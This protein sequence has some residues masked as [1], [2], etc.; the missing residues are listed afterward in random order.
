MK[1][2]PLFVLMLVVDFII[3][4]LWVY[5]MDPDP[6]SGIALV[7]IIPSVLIF[8]LL[9]GGVFYWAKKERLWLLFLINSIL[10]SALLFLLFQDGVQRNVDRSVESWT[11]QSGDSTFIL[12]RRKIDH[13]F[14]VDVKTAVNP[15]QE[16]MN[17]VVVE[18]GEGWVL[19]TDS[20]EMRIA[21]QQLI[22]FRNVEDTI[23]LRRKGS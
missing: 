13:T 4:W 22:N 2:L 19:K 7:F 18:S 23:Q 9:V 15:S 5:R 11:F 3:L 20:L 12:Y 8:N 14:Q 17:G 16:L 6:S 21:R 10:S 1:T